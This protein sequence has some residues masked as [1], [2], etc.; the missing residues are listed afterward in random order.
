MKINIALLRTLTPD[1]S[2]PPMTLNADGR[3]YRCRGH[4]AYMRD[5]GFWVGWLASSVDG[6]S[7][8]LTSPHPT[9]V[10]YAHALAEVNKR[11]Q[12][13]QIKEGYRPAHDV[14]CRKIL[15]ANR[16][17]AQCSGEIE[18][19][20]FEAV[21]TAIE[22]EATP[23][24]WLAK[25]DIRRTLAYEQLFH[26]KPTLSSP[27]LAGLGASGGDILYQGHLTYVPECQQW[28]AWVEHGTRAQRTRLKRSAVTS[29]PTSAEEALGAL[30]S[31]LSKAA[32]RYGFDAGEAIIA[33]ERVATEVEFIKL[34]RL[35][36]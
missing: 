12:R 22:L 8:R 28:V 17:Y 13:K 9:P 2:S 36:G 30:N 18:I 11:L 34:A 32:R 27:V 1:I 5:S 6:G 31:R 26:I 3:I 10:H 14:T 33:D 19:A 4:V 21:R 35:A 25:S 16:T 23:E 29:T 20:A 7:E 24:Q 15:S